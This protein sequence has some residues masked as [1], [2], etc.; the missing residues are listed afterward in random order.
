MIKA[1]II[2]DEAH[3]ITALQHDI[4][5]FCPDVEVVATCSSGAEG[6]EAIR[7]HKP[8]LIFLD[9]SMPLMTGF[10]MLEQLGYVQN[11]HVIFVTAFDQYVLQALRAS[12]LD[13]L[14]KPVNPKHLITALERFQV[15]KERMVTG[16]EQLENFL[17]NKNLQPEKQ[18]IALRN[19]D[20]FDF[21]S[22]G[23]IIYCRAEGSYTEIACQNGKKILI[24]KPLGDIEESLP[25]SLFERIHHSTIINVSCITQ[26]KR[27]EGFFVIMSNGETLTVARSRKDSLFAR[28]GIS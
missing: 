26:F 9:I 11:L 14:L 5:L 20:G 12:A 23:D 4:R 6:I 17:A 22:A 27:N 25:A 18:K 15:N 10:E 13:Y 19:K 28:L 1:L 24:S 2:D 21:V 3:C 16:R 8:E 7:R